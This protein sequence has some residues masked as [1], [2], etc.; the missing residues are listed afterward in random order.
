M[1]LK[2]GTCHVQR[3]AAKFWVG[4]SLV[5]TSVVFAGPPQATAA[6]AWSNCTV[7]GY[8][9][10]YTQFSGAGTKVSKYYDSTSWSG[11]SINN[12]DY[13]SANRGS[14]FVAVYNYYSGSWTASPKTFCMAANVYYNSQPGA[15]TGS[16]NRWTAASCF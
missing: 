13:S 3:K 14:Q 16:A 6:D 8:Q 7:S 2:F 9:C 12:N 1:P 4:L 10:V 5:C 15:G 11:T